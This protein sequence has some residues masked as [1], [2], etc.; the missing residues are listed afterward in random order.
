[1]VCNWTILL[2]LKTTLKTS[3]SKI[4]KGL[5]ALKRAARILDQKDLKTLYHALIYPYLTY[6]LL[7]WGGICRTHSSY[8]LLNT[9][10]IQNDMKSLS[11]VHKLQKRALRIISNIFLFAIPFN[12]STSSTSM[13]DLKAMSLLHDYYHNSLPPFFTNKFDFYHNSNELCLKIKYR[14]T[15]IA[16]AT[17]FHTLPNIWNPL[18][19]QIK[20]SIKKSKK[21]F[22]KEVKMYLLQAYEKWECR[23]IDCFVC[24]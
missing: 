9:G 10:P 6:G 21:T 23:E 15:E 18:P 14:R 19:V 13:I 11:I 22:L 3:V 7:V 5:Y 8:R 4:S 2:A 12:F 24:T 20:S 16:S 17:I 1:M